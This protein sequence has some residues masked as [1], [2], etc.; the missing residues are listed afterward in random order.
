MPVDP[1]FYDADIVILALNRSEETLQAIA[2][3]LGQRGCRFRLVVLDQGSVPETQARFRQALAGHSNAT[4]VASPR[5]LGV[6]GGRNAASALGHGRVIVGLDNDAVFA[7][8]HT[9]AEAVAAFDAM[10]DLGAL[11]FRIVRHDTG[12]DDLTSW[13]YPAGLLA[14]AGGSFDS[15]TFVGAGHA[16][17]RVAWD[18]AGGYD[19][20]LFF[21]WEEYDFCLRAIEADWRIRYRGDIVVRHHAAPEARVRWNANRWFY[22][23]RNRIYIGHKTGDGMV[24]LAARFAVYLARSLREGAAIQALRALPAAIRM[25]AGTPRRRLSGA[26]RDYLMRNDSRYRPALPGQFLA[27]L[28]GAGRPKA[29]PRPPHATLPVSP[30]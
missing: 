16:I 17:R 20:K 9:V 24:A 6:A 19:E 10:P 4:L 26:A 28:S 2:S 23:I 11:G 7:T 30:R 25:A 3:A 22:F 18:E 13:G 15:V 1:E 21:C 12:E 29:R 14:R 27:E 5:N 8:A